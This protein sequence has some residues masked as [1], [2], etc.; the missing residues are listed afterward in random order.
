MK[1][2][3]LVGIVLVVTVGVMYER[4]IVNI[5][6]YGQSFQRHS[7]RDSITFNCCVPFGDR[8]SSAQLSVSYLR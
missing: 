3:N 8:I 5:K 4:R 7:V 1:P 2:H 6:H